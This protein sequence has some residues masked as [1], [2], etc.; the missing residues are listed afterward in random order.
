MRVESSLE[1]FTTLYGWYLHD[2]MFDLVSNTGLLFVPLGW[3]IVYG[4]VEA[5][6]A[7]PNATESAVRSRR[8]VMVNGGIIMA[9]VLCGAVPFMSLNP[10]VLAYQRDCPSDAPVI[11]T[12]SGTLYDGGFAFAVRDVQVPIWWRFV[13]ALSAGVNAY[14]IASVGCV[15]DIAAMRI[16]VNNTGIKDPDLLRELE[17]FTLTCY[18]PSRSRMQREK[19]VT[20]QPMNAEND[21]LGAPFYLYTPGYYDFYYPKDGGVK[22][23]PVDL[24]RD[25]DQYVYDASGRAPAWGIPY[26]NDWWSNADRGLRKKIADEFPETLLD[27]V[28]AWPSGRS[29]ADR[30]DGVIKTLLDTVRIKAPARSDFAGTAFNTEGFSPTRFTA[31]IGLAI[32]E[33]S[34]GPQMEVIK[35][36][37]PIIKA[38]LMMGIYMLLPIVMLA[39]GYKLETLIVPALGIIAFNFL[40]VIWHVAWV[41]ENSMIGSMWT[42]GL[43]YLS[44]VVSDLGGGNF[45][46]KM[47]I[48][49]FVLTLL[50]LI[51][52]LVFILVMGWAGLQVMSG[53]GTM[54]NLATGTLGAAGRAGTAAA[55]SVVKR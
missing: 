34:F 20:P 5:A 29:E 38:F 28:L 10:G 32:E 52:P 30:I 4:M 54:M 36:G 11:A 53:L 41:L 13:M 40:S 55:K 14:V 49:D 9:V 45:A 17:Q 31:N 2:I 27:K 16:E 24:T 47:Q 3:A 1:L 48:L 51:L 6:R 37:L 46:I 18:L 8:P 35:A 15:D 22:G 26:C 44:Y 50:Y 33:F 7:T 42:D 12:D 43:D 25:T 21:W 23:W 39:G 19:P